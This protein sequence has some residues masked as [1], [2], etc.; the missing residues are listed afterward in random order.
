MSF[1]VE[2]QWAELKQMCGTE[3]CPEFKFESKWKLW[4]IK[5]YLV[6]PLR[7]FELTQN[8]DSLIALKCL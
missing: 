2:R 5:M 1:R 3:M 8:G 7:E 6:E 4:P